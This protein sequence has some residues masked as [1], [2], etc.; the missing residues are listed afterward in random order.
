[1]EELASDS[2]ESFRVDELVT[3][4]RIKARK[5]FLAN[6]ASR[7][8]DPIKFLPGSEFPKRMRESKAIAAKT[9]LQLSGLLK[10]SRHMLFDR[11]STYESSPENK[12]YKRSDAARIMDRIDKE[13]DYIS[14]T[15]I[16]RQPSIMRKP[17]FIEKTRS[18]VIVI[19]LQQAIDDLCAEIKLNSSK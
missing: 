8:E 18:T 7:R 3:A 4:T 13:G 12:K 14:K 19:S 10:Q 16:Q 11:A 15:R 1:M 5:M 17:T 9:S 6:R 2:D